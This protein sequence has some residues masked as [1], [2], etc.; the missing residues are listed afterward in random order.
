MKHYHVHATQQLRD[1]DGYYYD[2][3]ES[4]T[5]VDRQEAMVK[6][7]ELAERYTDLDDTLV[8]LSVCYL[9]VCTEILAEESA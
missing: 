4:F 2:E 5:I 9:E 3:V 6:T 8:L 1:L 7:M